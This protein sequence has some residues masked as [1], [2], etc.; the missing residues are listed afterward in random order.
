MGNILRHNP[1]WETTLNNQKKRKLTREDHKKN[2]SRQRKALLLQVYWNKFEGFEKIT[3]PIEIIRENG[4]LNMSFNV[5]VLNMIRSN[6]GF[7]VPEFIKFCIKNDY[8]FILLQYE[9]L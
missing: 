9:P 4:L 1:L 8:N 6:Y 5:D 2:K 3:K 7:D